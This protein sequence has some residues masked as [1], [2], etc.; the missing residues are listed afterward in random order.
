MENRSGLTVDDIQLIVQIINDTITARM[1]IIPIVNSTA[2]I[3][4]QDTRNASSAPSAEPASPPAAPLAAPY[5]PVAPM[6]PT[7][8][9]ED[10]SLF[11]PTDNTEEV[12][13]TE[14]KYI[15]YKDVFTFTDR[16]K[17]L[18]VDDYNEARIS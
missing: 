13:A 2:N 1:G 6:L 16:L 18:A 12:M 8:K 10:I 11:E 4:P 15:I 7:L 9:P 14:G 17:Q 5:A 3:A